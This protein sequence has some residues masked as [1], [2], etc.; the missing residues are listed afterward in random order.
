MKE[1]ANVL[2]SI[3]I[4]FSERVS[5]DILEKSHAQILNYLFES[6]SC[7]YNTFRIPAII[8][9]T[10]GTLL[11]FAEGRKNTSSD[12][13]DI[14]LV[15]KRSEDNGKTW[16]DLKVIWDDGSNVCGNPAPVQ[17]KVTGKIY[18][19]STWNLGNDNEADIIK[20]KSKDTRRI[21][22]LVS[23]D[24]G[25]TWSTPL[26]IS[27]SVKMSNWTWYATGPCHGI[28]IVNGKFSGRLV[29]PCDHIE[30]GTE[31]Y[32]S[33]II[34]SDD[35]G[36]SWKLGGTTPQPQV[37]E[38]SVA[39]LQSGKL[40]L[41]MRN[42]DLTQR[43]RKITLSD[44]GGLTWGDIYSD[45]VLIEPICQASLMSC[46]NIK[47]DRNKLLF[48]NPSDETSRKNLTLRISYDDGKTWVV[49][50]VIYA[51]PSAYSDLAALSS[52]DIALLFEAGV[53]SPYQGIV[54]QTI[55]FKD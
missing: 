18:L 20:G 49:S 33:H 12:T 28:Q 42:Y 15:M 11:A 3:I 30:A 34:Y 13:G 24:N 40:M 29:I 26:E 21:F 14:D 17:D 1:Y 36:N 27:A 19:L 10:H 7:G 55:Q 41:N 47:K 52:G 43:S 23:S 48:L 35:N 46:T 4:L 37:N 32:Y 22:V 2:L 9:T 39:E 45:P 54:F 6:G 50:L 8:S 25:M 51:G 16:S 53:T 38:C 5:A 44:D 31:N